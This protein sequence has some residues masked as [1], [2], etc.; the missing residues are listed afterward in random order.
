MMTMTMMISRGRLRREIS[1]ISEYLMP[2]LLDNGTL[3]PTGSNQIQVLRH[4]FAFHCTT[5]YLGTEEEQAARVI[6][7]IWKA[8]YEKDHADGDNSNHTSRN[9]RNCNRPLISA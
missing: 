8:P 2:K 9:V 7:A 3:V 1:S 4:Q 6:P 5:S